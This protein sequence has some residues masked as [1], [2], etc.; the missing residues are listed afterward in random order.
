MRQVIDRQKA[1]I[2]WREGDM[3][4][5][6]ALLRRHAYRDAKSLVLY[7]LTVLPYRSFEKVRLRYHGF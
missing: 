7:G 4:T 5:C 2:A 6:R 1:Q 3:R